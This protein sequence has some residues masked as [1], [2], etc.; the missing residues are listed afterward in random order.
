MTTL[1]SCHGPLTRYAKL[2]VAHAQVMPERFPC[3]RLRRKPLFGDP[4]VQHGTC[5]THVP[6]RMSGSLTRGG[7]AKV[8]DIPGVYTA[9][10]FTN[11]VRDP[12]AN[13]ASLNLDES[14]MNVPANLKYDG[15]IVGEMGHRPPVN[16]V[17]HHIRRSPLMTSTVF[18]IISVT[19]H[20]MATAIPE[21]KVYGD[22]SWGPT[23]PRWAPR[24]PPW[25]LLSGML[26]W[27]IGHDDVIRWKHFPRYWPYVRGIHRSLVS[28][29][30]K[31]S[32][33]ELWCFLRSVPDYTIDQTIA[34]LVIWDAIAPIMTSV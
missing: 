7:G 12:C 5:V 21:S 25:D 2:G 26:T 9:R 32:D 4:G 15:K 30:T 17:M 10:N 14:G 8:P 3:H 23:G 19:W 22:I 27:I 33:A 31:A 20:T 16:T 29:H 28:S 24:W 18:V 34:R 11:L 13:I 6:W 1:L